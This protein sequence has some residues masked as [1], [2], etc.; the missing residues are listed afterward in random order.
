MV[1]A[2]T[3]VAAVAMLPGGSAFTTSMPSQRLQLRTNSGAFCK[4]AKSLNYVKNARRLE[5]VTG[6]KMEMLGKRYWMWNVSEWAFDKFIALTQVGN[7]V[8]INDAAFRMRPDD[9]H[10]LCSSVCCF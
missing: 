9:H 2:V 4:S 1:A 10:L 3:A 8:K 5:A 6:L 7:V